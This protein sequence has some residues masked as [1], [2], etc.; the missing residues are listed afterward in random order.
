[1][2]AEYKVAAEYKVVVVHKD[3]KDRQVKVNV[4]TDII[5]TIRI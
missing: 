2:R 5:N 3:Q 1:V 4:T